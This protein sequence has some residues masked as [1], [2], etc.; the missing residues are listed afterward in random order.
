MTKTYLITGASEGIGLETARL[1]VASGAAVL[2][3]ARDAAKL[4]AAANGLPGAI[5][6]QIVAVDL[7]DPQALNAF[8]AAL[9]AQ[10]YVPEVLV[11]NAGHGASGAFADADWAKI[12]VMLRLNINALARLSHWAARGMKARKS[13]SIVNLSAAVATRPTPYFAAYAASKAFVTNLSI[14][15]F[16]ELR[17]YGVSVSAIHPPAVRTSFG[18]AGK[19]DLKT[20]LVHKLFPTVGP[21]T[22]A[23]AVMSAVRRRRRSVIIGPVAAIVMGTAPILPRGFDLAFMTLLFKGKRAAA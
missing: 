20:T 7:A 17:A 19:A 8:I 18:T 6:P 4:Q 1:A 23:R 3:V 13:G 21:K 5:R 22:V 16:S 2:M 15:M 11:N 9:D 10:G 14:A 12:D